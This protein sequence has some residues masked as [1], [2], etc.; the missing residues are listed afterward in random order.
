MKINWL[1]RI[2]NKTFWMLLIPAVMV[3][4]QSVAA[5]FG[6]TLDLG[7]LGNKLV[8]IVESVFAILGII[9]VVVD[10]T[11]QGVN[12]SSRAMSYSEPWS[13]AAAELMGE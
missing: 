6:F 11:T 5:L 7:E 10:P 13:D 1:A 8:A 3:A 2:K 12:D 9:G 4:V